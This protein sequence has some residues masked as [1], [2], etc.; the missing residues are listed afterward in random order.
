MTVVNG[1]RAQ[2]F[3]LMVTSSFAQYPARP[4]QCSR[5]PKKHIKQ[6]EITSPIV[7]CIWHCRVPPRKDKQV[8]SRVRA[9]S[10]SS[11]ASGS[12]SS[13]LGS[14]NRPLIA[15]TA[16]R[17]TYECLQGITWQSAELLVWFWS[18]LPCRRECFT[19]VR[20]A[21]DWCVLQ[22]PHPPLLTISTSVMHPKIQTYTLN[23]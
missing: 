16:F 15:S 20:N 7:S 6:I 9:F 21:G 22:G 2:V 14:L 1:T 5:Q 13:P 4:A 17:R 3:P 19:Q 23:A 11:G 18:V 10:I 12:S 8:R